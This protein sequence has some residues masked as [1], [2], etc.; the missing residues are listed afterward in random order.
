MGRGGAR[1]FR[2]QP[3]RDAFSH[4]IDHAGRFLNDGLLVL[5]EDRFV[6]QVVLFERL[7]LLDLAVHRAPVAVRVG[8][9]WPPWAP[10]RACSEDGLRIVAAAVAERAAGGLV[11]CHGSYHTAAHPEVRFRA[12]CC[13]WLF[14]DQDGVV[15]TEQ[16]AGNALPAD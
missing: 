6:E 11:V 2:P 13:G 8:I 12:G 14:G 16:P 5:C 7:R 3:H 15:D 1:F 10:R 4:R 9:G